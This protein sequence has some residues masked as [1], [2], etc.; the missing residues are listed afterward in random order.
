MN[1]DD[2]IEA[3]RREKEAR[4]NSDVWRHE[5]LLITPLSGAL[6]RGGDIEH[7][8]E[9][10]PRTVIAFDRTVGYMVSHADFQLLTACKALLVNA[11]EAKT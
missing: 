11:K 6:I 3:C 1:L 10:L 5:S 7:I 9:S 2:A 4:P 8:E